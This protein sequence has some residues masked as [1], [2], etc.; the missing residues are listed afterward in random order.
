[1][2]NRHYFFSPILSL[3]KMFMFCFVVRLQVLLSLLSFLLIGTQSRGT[4][5]LT[6][7]IFEKARTFKFTDVNA[8]PAKD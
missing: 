6:S 5:D 8:K 4:Y 7:F 2:D 3:Y 1:M